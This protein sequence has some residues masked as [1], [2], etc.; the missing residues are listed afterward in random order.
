[1]N[2]SLSRAKLAPNNSQGAKGAIELDLP[3]APW[4]LA[5]SLRW[6]LG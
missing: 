4:L 2:Q 6:P 1:M 5:L 3:G